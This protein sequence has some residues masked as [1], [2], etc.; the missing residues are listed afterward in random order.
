[1]E[2][3]RVPDELAVLEVESLLDVAVVRGLDLPEDDNE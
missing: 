2:K 1:V 3:R